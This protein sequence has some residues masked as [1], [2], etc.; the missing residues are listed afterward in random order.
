[1]SYRIRIVPEAERDIDALYLWIAERSGDGA[2]R[3]YRRLLEVLTTIGDNPHG[4]ERAPEQTLVQREIRHFNFRTR[5]GR[6]YRV[7]FEVRDSEIIV[8]HVR[9]PGQRLLRRNE[10]RSD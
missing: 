6:P 9:G 2:Q 8:L 7:L 1:M 10:L 5:R 4:C 3:W